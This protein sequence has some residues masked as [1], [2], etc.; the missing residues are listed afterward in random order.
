MLT[1][2]G[3]KGSAYMHKILGVESPRVGHANIG[4]EES[5]VREMELETYKQLKNAPVNF[6]GN[7]EARQLP[8]GDCDVCVADGFCGNLMLKLYDVMAKFFSVD[9]KMLLT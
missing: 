9:L 3:I 2:I 8:M 5:K 4:A 1:Q 6:V 7:I